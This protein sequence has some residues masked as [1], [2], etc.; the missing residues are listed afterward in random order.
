MGYIIK[1]RSEQL[2]KSLPCFNRHTHI[3]TKCIRKTIPLERLIFQC[4]YGYIC[5]WMFMC[6]FTEYT[7]TPLW[8][9]T[10][11][12]ATFAMCLYVCMGG[13]TTALQTLRLKAPPCCHNYFETLF[14]TIGCPSS[15]NPPWNGLCTNTHVYMGCVTLW[16]HIFVY[17][18]V[19]FISLLWLLGSYSVLIVDM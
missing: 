14:F 3:H 5:E 17:V 19:W 8:V 15:V 11:A 6:V 16:M 7:L 1:N 12:K 13:Q 10:P 18:N 4:P 9:L 2:Q